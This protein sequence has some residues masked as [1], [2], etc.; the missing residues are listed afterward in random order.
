LADTCDSDENGTLNIADS[1]SAQANLEQIGLLKNSFFVILAKAGIQ[2]FQ[3]LLD[4]CHRRNDISQLT[5]NGS[6]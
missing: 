2:S 3:T 1:C 6:A 5:P 4:S